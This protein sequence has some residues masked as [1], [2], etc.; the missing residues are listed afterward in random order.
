M[1]QL[2]TL[3]GR[4]L[5]NECASV[6]FDQFNFFHASCFKLLVSRGLSVGII[7]GAVIVKFPQIFKIYPSGNIEGLALSSYILSLLAYTI[8]FSYSF[9][10]GFAFSTYGEN[11]VMTFQDMAIVGLIMYYSKVDLGLMLAVGGLYLG[12]VVWLLS[13]TVPR[14]LFIT[15]Q[16]STILLT[17]SSKLPQ[18]W[19]NFTKSST[20]QLSC[21]T[22]VS[23][24]LGCLGRIFTTLQEV[25][26]IAILSGH[27]LAGFLNGVL[28]LQILYYWKR[29]GPKEAKRE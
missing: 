27:V 21:L 16:S 5:N 19:S 26:D 2:K 15:L 28:V 22:T 6:Y 13:G 12:I 14:E 3:C 7:L 29:T 9:S 11:L 18:I 17:V 24:F 25:N 23:Q 20:G 8:S 4:F 1:D 10:N